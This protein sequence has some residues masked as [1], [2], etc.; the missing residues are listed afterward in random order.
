[1][2]GS[3]P[4]QVD[5]LKWA[6]LVGFAIGMPYVPKCT[7]HAIDLVAFAFRKNIQRVKVM[8]CAPSY[9]SDFMSDIQRMFAIAELNTT[10]TLDT[11]ILRTSDH[12]RHEEIVRL[13]GHLFRRNTQELM[14]A[15]KSPQWDD[16]VLGKM[17]DA[18]Q[19]IFALVMENSPIR[20]GFEAILSACVTGAWTAFE[21]MCGDLWEVALNIQPRKLAGLKGQPK[22]FLP[23]D[24]RKGDGKSRDDDL[25]IPDTTKIRLSLIGRYGYNLEEKMG[26]LLRTIQRFDSLTGIRVAYGS[27]FAT[28]NDAIGAALTDKSLDSLAALRN[29]LVH[30]SG[31]VDETYEK[32]SKYLPFLPKAP[33]GME[34]ALDGEIVSALL[35]QTILK[36]GDLLTAVDNWIT[37]SLASK[38]GSE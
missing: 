26:T 21:T 16:F 19:P 9:A 37:T 32:R 20:Q 22:R 23:S 35:V 8:A 1:M 17:R 15:A 31:V 11:T 2:S 18:T 36:S 10:G 24:E 25:E 33:I 38:D 3:P 6:K 12:P 34:I 14:E 29:I 5:V 30:K 27:A 7:N 4:A 28:N 13:A